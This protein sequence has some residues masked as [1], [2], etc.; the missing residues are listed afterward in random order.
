[1][2]FKRALFSFASLLIVSSCELINP[3]EEIPSFI[4]IDSFVMEDNVL[5]DEGS[6]SHDIRD[7]WVFI[8][9]EM[10]GIYELPARIPILV[11]IN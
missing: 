4:Q 1:L 7:A 5:A 9:D 2:L 10:I 8:D 3:V 11:F 6:L